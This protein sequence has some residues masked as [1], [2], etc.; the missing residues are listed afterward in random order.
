MSFFLYS[1][2]RCFNWKFADD[3]GADHDTLRC[4]LRQ[5]YD[6]NQSTLISAHS[7]S[8]TLLSPGYDRTNPGYYNRNYCIY[9]ISLDC[10]SNVVELEPTSRTTGLSDAQP[11]R[12]YLSFHVDSQRHPLIKLCGQDVADATKY[13]DIQ[14]NNFYGVLWSNHNKVQ[15]GLF[16]II[17]RCKNIPAQGSGA[18]ELELAPADQ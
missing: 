12:D 7:S 8:A 2:V 17:A 15:S 11:C 4:R 1:T 13:S 6:F 3:C 10:P 5:R 9:N 18:G 16:E 14:S